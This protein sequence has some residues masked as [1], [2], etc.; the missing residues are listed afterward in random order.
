MSLKKTMRTFEWTRKR[1]IN[2]FML[3]LFIIIFVFIILAPLNWFLWGAQ[4]IEWTTWGYIPTYT[5]EGTLYDLPPIS[6][7]YIVT[8]SAI[9]SFSVNNPI[10]VDILIRNVSLP[11]LLDH[12]QLI[13][14][15]EAYDYPIKHNADGSINSASILLSYAGKDA[16]YGNDS[17]AGRG[18]V[19]WMQE[20]DKYGPVLAPK[21]IEVTLTIDLVVKY[22]HDV[23]YISGISDTLAQTFTETANKLTLTL[24]SFSIIVL[25][26][27]LEAIFVQEETTV[28]PSQPQTQQPQQHRKKGR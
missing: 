19:I 1:K 4:K 20:G 15:G 26:P 5:L 16:Y 8:F 18:E 14:F 12:F 21:D 24:G 2:A 27:V 11:N 23:L 7:E 28:Q 6:Y 9:G 13:S 22:F 10:A 25:A 3:A 17:Y